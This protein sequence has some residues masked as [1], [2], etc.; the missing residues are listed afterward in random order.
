MQLSTALFNW[1]VPDATAFVTA[2]LNAP[3][4]KKEKEALA[5]PKKELCA[6]SNKEARYRDPET[7][8]AYRDSRAFGVLRGVVG[9]GFVWCGELGCYV[10]GRAKPMQSRGK[11]F[12]GMAPAAGVPKR[13]LEMEKKTP[14]APAPEAVA[15]SKP[16]EAEGSGKAAPGTAAVP[17]D[18]PDAT[19]VAA[20][21]TEEKAVVA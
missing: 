16:G 21:K 19:P 14:V 10:G 17:G 8:I 15:N 7:G 18:A 20:V 13:F 1:S 2:M 6:V 9:G 3:K 5:R 12:L 4:T 11:G